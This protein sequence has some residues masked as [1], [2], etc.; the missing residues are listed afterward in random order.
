MGGLARR[1]EEMVAYLAQVIRAPAI[2]PADGGGPGGQKLIEGEHD[3]GCDQTGRDV[4]RQ[5]CR[6]ARDAAHQA[7]APIIESK[8]GTERRAI[9]LCL[10]VGRVVQQSVR[11]EKE[12][13]HDRGDEIEVTHGDDAKRDRSTQQERAARIFA[14]AD[15]LGKGFKWREYLIGSE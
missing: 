4:D 7:D 13:R 12:H 2:C 3:R 5:H 9:R 11:D 14:R 8:G 1:R 6:E 10:V 15:A